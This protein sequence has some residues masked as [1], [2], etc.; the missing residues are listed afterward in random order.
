MRFYL[1]G[2]RTDHSTSKQV[3]KRLI[4]NSLMVMVLTLSLSSCSDDPEPEQAPVTKVS[5]PQ[6]PS[7]DYDYQL[8]GVQ[9]QD[10]YMW[11]NQKTPQR[12]EWMEQQTGL[13]SEYFSAIGSDLNEDQTPQEIF[14]HLYPQ[15]YVNK[16]FY[17]KEST[18][19]SS[20]VIAIYDSIKEVETE[21]GKLPDNQ[22]VVGTSLSPEGRFFAVQTQN[23]QEFYRWYI[24]DLAQR[25][26]HSYRLPAT[27]LQTEFNW[28]DGFNRFI[29]QTDQQVHYLNLGQGPDFSLPLF[30]LNDHMDDAEQWQINAKLTDD[31]RYLLVTAKHL[32]NT[33]DQLWV[34][35]ITESGEI[36]SAIS[37]AKN[38]RASLNFVGNINETF[39]FHTN[40]VAPRWRIIS[41]NLNQPS[42]RDWKEVVSQQNELLISAQLI[43]NRWL[44]HY[45]NNTQQKVYDSQLNGS[46]KE[47]I[48]VTPNSNLII[49]RPKTMVNRRLSSLATISSFQHPARIFAIDTQT[50]KLSNSLLP[51]EET[52][53]LVSETVFYRS[54]DGSRIP[55][56]LTYHEEISKDGENPTLLITNQGFGHIQLPYYSPFFTDWLSKGGVIAIAH[57]RGG[58][59][60]GE[61]WRQSVGGQKHARA[62]EDIVSAVDWLANNNFSKRQYIAAYGERF[63]GS[64]LMEAAIHA[65][66]NFRAL[67]LKNIEANYLNKLEEKD[68]YWMKEFMLNSDQAS[69]EWFLAV[70]PYHRLTNKNYPAALIIDDGNEAAVS[71]YKTL[72]KWQNLQL[73][74][75]PILLLNRDIA[76]ELND[77]QDFELIILE[78]IKHFLSNE[79][80]ASKSEQQA[81]P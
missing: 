39:Y 72:A 3:V 43:D 6:N 25:N 8:N 9:I 11:L 47:E 67:V 33:S 12:T 4:V 10:H 50:R 76:S 64:L 15:Q 42:R 68:P 28:L 41:I 18:L 48:K 2:Y 81:Q 16:F 36:Q 61:S 77:E 63:A 38:T 66:Q 19:K 54:S 74:P 7:Q 52:S 26:F 73:S 1:Q 31:N 71:N 13:V 46:A 27:H 29:Y 17:I 57:I 22:R 69:T 55:L 34:L 78:A 23:R 24:F 56:T 51:L 14:N 5:L 60:Y 35:P 79:L 53:D 75:R 49:Q 30:D 80:R 65:P 20:N 37:L 21:L 32:I 45:L 62:V 44:L 59:I 70:S 58:G 40:L